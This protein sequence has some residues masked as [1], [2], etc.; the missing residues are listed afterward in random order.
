MEFGK[1]K[2][3]VYVVHPS[4]RVIQVSSARKIIT[5]S[6]YQ[7]A[8]LGACLAVRLRNPLGRLL[9]L[10]FRQSSHSKLEIPLV[11][12]KSFGCKIV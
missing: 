7:R 2:Q 8:A 5:H 11:C 9:P 6:I 10:P 4:E 1:I 3:K 12:A